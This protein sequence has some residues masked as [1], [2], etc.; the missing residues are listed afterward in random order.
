MKKIIIT[1]FILLV[2]L[3]AGYIKESVDAH[4]KGE[5]KK[6]ANIY[7]KACNEGKASACY[8]LG[9]LY[10]GSKGIKKD[11]KSAMKY[12]KKA[13]DDKFT[14]ACYNLGVI[15]ATGKDVP[16]NINR[17]ISLYQKACKDNDG[18]ACNN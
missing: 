16:K 17:A 1:L 5:H 4:K 18:A 8:N 9:I 14:S 10:M 11:V 15:Y 6:V 3:E 7:E 13:C 2:T 12:Y